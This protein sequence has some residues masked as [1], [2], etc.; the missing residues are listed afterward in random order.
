[1]RRSDP[2]MMRGYDSL[3]PKVAKLLSNKYLGV[4]FC[5]YME[6]THNKKKLTF[7]Q[8]LYSVVSLG[9]VRPTLRVIGKILKMKKGN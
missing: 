7:A 5:N 8:H 6:A 1:M 2:D 9:V 4:F 3:G